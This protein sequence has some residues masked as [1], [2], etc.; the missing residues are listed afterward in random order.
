MKTIYTILLLLLCAILPAEA[1]Q[2]YQQLWADVYRQAKADRPKDEMNLLERISGIASKENNYGQML[3]ADLLRLS[4]VRQTY[5]DDSLTS[6][7]LQL[8]Q[9]RRE[10]KAAHPALAAV[11]ACA[12]RQKDEALADPALLA[13]TKATDF[14][15]LLIPGNEVFGGDLLRRHRSLFELANLQR[16]TSEADIRDVKPCLLLQQ[17][18]HL[19]CSVGRLAIACLLFI[20]LGIYSPYHVVRLVRANIIDED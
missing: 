5:G 4:L 8:E 3:T 2:N 1:Q 13:H 14:S 17:E 6:V 20:T 10:T 15:P 18:S 9:K 11:Y 7:R 19:H 12:L 16:E